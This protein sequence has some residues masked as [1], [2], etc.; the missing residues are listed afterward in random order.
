M[1]DT[2]RDSTIADT[3]TRAAEVERDAYQAGKAAAGNRGLLYVIGGFSVLAGILAIA[4]PFVASLAAAFTTGWVLVLS[5]ILGL[6]AAFRRGSGWQFV[7]AFA[8]SLVMIVAG[9]LFIL[10]PIAGIIAL[11]TLIVAYFGAV[12]I[13]RVYYGVKSLGDGGGWMAALGA[14]SVAVAVLLWFGMPLNA[15]WVPGVLLGIDLIL[16]GTLLIAMGVR[17]GQAPDKRPAA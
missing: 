2:D 13:L 14:L 10:Q 7:A 3:D 9:I 1:T 8:L 16:W 6:A 5:G 11:T 17:T 15:V 12:G 4:M